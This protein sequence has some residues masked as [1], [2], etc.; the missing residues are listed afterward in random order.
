MSV[1]VAR[2]N[3]SCSCRRCIFLLSD[4]GLE[5]IEDKLQTIAYPCSR[6]AT[7]TIRGLNSGLSSKLRYSDFGTNGLINFKSMNPCSSI[8]KPSSN[9]DYLKSFPLLSLTIFL[10]PLPNISPTTILNS[11]LSSILCTISALLLF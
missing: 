3:S 10:N 1:V 4:H 11:W 2:C 5:L 9:F 6:I 7:T 8:P